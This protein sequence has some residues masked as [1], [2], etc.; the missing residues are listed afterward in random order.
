MA[1]TYKELIIPKMSFINKSGEIIKCRISISSEKKK[2]DEKI[3]KQRVL[4]LSFDNNDMSYN[5]KL[6]NT[7]KLKENKNLPLPRQP[8]K[9]TDT[10]LK[11]RK[12][13]IPKADIKNTS[14]RAVP[15]ISVDI[16][17]QT[18]IKACDIPFPLP[19]KITKM[20]SKDSCSTADSKRKSTPKLLTNHPSFQSLF[21]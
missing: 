11:E 1:N 18:R 7:P 14:K 15:N 9:N 13:S 19:L 4:N 12:A 17:T 10:K 21:K 20:K 3:V 8:K 6:Y 2:Q 5:K 16:S